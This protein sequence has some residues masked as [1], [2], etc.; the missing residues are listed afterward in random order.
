MGFGT[1]ACG[2]CGVVGVAYLSALCNLSFTATQF[3]L[4]SAAASIV[5]RFVTG[6]TAGGLIVQMGYVNFYLLTTLL[7]LPGVALFAWLMK[8][9]LVAASIAATDVRRAAEHTAKGCPGG[10]SV[11]VVARERRMGG[12]TAQK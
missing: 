7:A 3:A 6:T 1:F 11:G 12:E 10:A 4:L 9:G 2:S 8:A 5:G